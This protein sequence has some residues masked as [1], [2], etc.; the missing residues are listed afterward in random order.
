MVRRVTFFPSRWFVLIALSAFGLSA[1]LPG[2]SDVSLHPHTPSTSQF[3]V[4]SSFALS[5][6]P[7]SAAAGDLN[8]D[9]HPDLVLTEKGSGNVTVLLG[10]GKGGF[11][12]GV[13]YPAGTL[14]SNVQVADL[15]HDGKLDLVVTD[16]AAGTIDVLLGNGD[17]TFAKAVS[18]PAVA[19][20]V[21][22][23]VGNFEGKGKIDVAVAG[24]AGLAVLLND[25]SGR[26]SAPA[27]L[28]LPAA[29]LS[30]TAADFRGAGHDDL[31]LA[32]QDGTITMLLGDGA[33]AFHAQPAFSASSGSLSGIVS[34]DFNGDSKPDLALSAAGA[35]SVLVLL[36]H[37]DGSF[38]PGVS[39]AVGRSPAS[40]AAA[41][42]T[43]SGVT[44]LVSV[45][46]GANTFSVLHG[47]G[48]GTFA[49]AADF[50]AGSS[51]LALVASDF[52]SD[53]RAD[54]A[55]ANFGDSTVS[56]PLGRGDGT[57]MA[58]RVYK[59]GYETRSIAAGDL[60]GDGRPDLVVAS[61]CGSDP[62]CAG[63]GSATVYLANADGTY[64][65]GSTIALGTGPI[66]VALADL[67]GDKKPD[68]LALN[69]ADK[70]M[71]VMPGNGDGT[72][73]QPQLY[74]LPSSPTALFVGDFN[75]DAIPDLAIAFDC[76]QSSCSEP[77]TLEVWLGR[78]DDSLAASDSYT[79]G[80]SPVSIAAGDLFGKG[81][82]DLVVANA[83][84]DSACQ[85]DGTASILS[86]NGAGKFVLS[87]Q[88]DIGKAPSAI[89]LGNLSGS[90]LDLAIAQRSANQV[91]VMHWT[92]S[93]FGAPVAYSAGSAP[94][95]LAI[96]DFNGDGNLDLA[97]ANFQSSTISLFNGTGSGSLQAARTY[98]AATGPESL[99]A[100]GNGVGQ[101]SSLA[102]ANGNSG[103]SPAG[104]NFTLFRIHPFAQ[105]PPS[106]VDVTA[107]PTTGVVDGTEVLTA[108]VNGTAGTAPTGTVTF[109]FGAADGA[110]SCAES[111]GGNGTVPFSS[112]NTGAGTAT[113]TCTTTSLPAGSL[114]SING[115]YNGDANYNS[116]SGVSAPLT[117]DAA[118][119]STALGS[120]GTSSNLNQS[121]TFTATV[122][123][124]SNS[125]ALSGNVTFTDNGAAIT[126]GSNCGTAG[127]VLISGAGTAT[128]TTSALTEGTH[129]IIATYGTDL[130]YLTSNNNVIQT[131]SAATTGTA[132][133]S[134]ATSTGGSS[135]TAVINS[136]VT[137]TATISPHGSTVPLSGTVTFLEGATPVAG[138]TVAF[139][140]TTGQATCTT[141]SLALG[142]HTITAKYAGDS[143][144]TT[145]NA[146]LTQVITLGATGVSLG[147]SSASPAVN[148]SVTL[149]A[150]VTANAPGSSPTQL[151]GSVNFTDTPQGGTATAICSN[152]AVSPSTGKATCNDS[153]N[154]AGS[155]TITAT[156]A[157]DTNFAGNS[158]TTSESVGA[159][160][161]SLALTSSAPSP[162]VNQSPAVVFKATITENP[163]GSTGLTATASFYDT[164]KGGASTAIPGCA[165]VT[166][167]ATS[168]SGV[169]TAN[170]TDAALTASGSQHTI[171]AYYGETPF[172]TSDPNF[173]GSS[174]TLTQTVNQAAS[175]VVVANPV[176][177][178]T[179]NQSVTFT[180]T[181]TPN[182]SGSV[183]LS[184]SVSFSDTFTPQGSGT[185]NAPVTL[186]AASTASI[187]GSGT[188]IVSCNSATLGLGKHAI[189]ATYGSDSNFTGSTS[190]VFTQNVGTGSGNIALTSSSP[191]NSSTVNQS[192]TFT[193][194]IPVPSGN[195]GLTGTVAF[196]DNGATLGT[197]G[198]VT[199]TSGVATCASASLLASATPHTI[200]AAY[201]GDQNFSFAN[202]TLSQTVTPAGS[203][204]SLA[205][206]QSPSVVNQ[207]ITFTATVTPNPSGPTGLNGK[208]AFI[209]SVSAATIAGC[210]ALPVTTSA[211]KTTAVCSTAGLAVSPPAHTITATYSSDANFN[212][213]SNTFVQTV[214]S[215]T[216]NINLS[217][218][219]AG[220][221]S[222][223]NQSVTFTAEIPVPS[224]A[225]SPTGKV[226]F[227]DNG[228]TTICSGVSPTQTAG[229][230]NWFANCTDTA[231]TAGTHTIVAAYGGD[232][233]LTVGNGSV[234]QQVGQGASTTGLTSSLSP[235]FPVNG[236]GSNYKDS[237]TYTATVAAPAG[238]L[239]LSLGTVAFTV[240]GTTLAGCGAVAPS[241]GLA[242]CTTTT[243][244]FVDGANGVVATYSGDPNYVASTGLYSQIVEDYAISVGPVPTPPAGAA[245]LGVLVTQ[246]FTSATDPFSPASL[247][248]TSASISGFAGAP[249]LVCT[250]TPS[251]GAPKC[252]LANSALTISGANGAVQQSAGIVLDASSATPGTYTFT[253]TATDSTSSIVRT[254]TFPATVVAV[255]TPLTV[256]SGAT[257]KNTTTLT[258]VLPG[259]VSLPLSSSSCVEVVGPEFS[260]TF[261]A[262]SL[263]I[264]CSFNPTKINSTVAQQSASVVATILTNSSTVAANETGSHT[265]LLVAGVFGLPLFGLLGMLR[266]RRSMRSV[267]LRTLAI[268]AIGAAGWQAMGCGGSF[269]GSTNNAGGKTPPGSYDILVEGTGSDG[270]TYRAVIVLNVE[271]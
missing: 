122:S 159:A 103:A 168:P 30:L 90:G 217:S 201:S 260:G 106:A 181:V 66:A 176:N 81:H 102:A 208:V 160:S 189:T 70:S 73:G 83:C 271:L 93:T 206:S 140:V 21:A 74:S 218:S 143:S 16:S 144:Y 134:S 240:N 247:S 153:W 147:T 23:A 7:T 60:N 69:R 48:D 13:A 9:G 15:N 191:A 250:A 262:A 1:S 188:G 82:L 128:C 216:A 245:N 229:T 80:Y 220:N 119:T 54:L 18:Y 59:S 104:T 68:L 232:S 236:N 239:A 202:G 219:S 266:G 146:T 258:F 251:A 253:V 165:N 222:T 125:V 268:V 221:T 157:N 231:L 12:A 63:N 186:C 138:C 42:L 126:S 257:T 71:T 61:V 259:G 190:A 123:A 100:I 166:V 109:S 145:S 242:T 131:V 116:L 113:A 199:P 184:G 197:C 211:G 161:T 265:T 267:F 72:F 223:V 158:G 129:A 43:G 183:A 57:F 226:S 11:A 164:P 171:T 99:V 115:L 26:F 44:D 79:V 84:G 120:S 270:N 178:S 101:P 139:N 64:R 137:L 62:A 177:P 214:N 136:A 130:N 108:V 148:Q 45:N 95:A 162:T 187:T 65:A 156:Y 225:P 29:P 142:S 114:T 246:G 19:N 132:F 192:V 224:G 53:G 117:I 91:A 212:G 249:T 213:S 4:A 255:A 39:Y 92:G 46:Q 35:N 233:N 163:V 10:D 254:T 20:P 6:A 173:G 193:A 5:S 205:S 175:S 235:A 180:A 204:L 94:S 41:D 40:I 172:T 170:C 124:P 3:V 112:S 51:P 89:A 228:A 179:V 56:V 244:G 28:A 133:V 151:S 152:V 49:P 185:A 252:N 215:A 203:T 121:V 24:T 169:A 135:Y 167:S 241:A 50:V 207:S 127:V 111:T 58:A 38:A 17:G 22:L 33:G 227:S 77:G 87:G 52:N 86:G 118:A 243:A 75:G 237:V 47:N 105:V 98:S 76:G 150:T 200:V 97:A 96:A 256:I 32:N 196:T 234:T 209:D 27:S 31:A 37:G 210:G 174:N 198:A 110:V 36:G 141:S 14:A 154:A 78:G 195:T 107:S 85:T 34:G 155:H 55:I 149:T 248:A 269:T 264:S 67:D 88:V 2:Q 25:G 194:S 238:G 182:P 263:N 8:G 261:T 230:S